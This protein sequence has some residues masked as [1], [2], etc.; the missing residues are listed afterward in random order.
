MCF[1]IPN[2][3]IFIPYISDNLPQ[4]AYIIGL[5]DNSNG[6][7]IFIGDDDKKEEVVT[8]INFKYPEAY[9]NI[10]EGCRLTLLDNLPPPPLCTIYKIENSKFLEF[11]HRENKYL[12]VGFK[13][14]THYLIL[15]SDDCID[16][17][18]EVE[19]TVNLLLNCN[20][21]R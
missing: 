5:Q 14:I 21:I 6:L 4:N 17:L 19:P 13:N 10:D 20:F 9:M 7:S 15:T 1:E 16:V 8:E 2:K 11:F 12:Y 3:E 18:S